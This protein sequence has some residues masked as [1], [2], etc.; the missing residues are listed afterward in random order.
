[1]LEHSWTT[2]RILRFAVLVILVVA[3]LRI[4]A[5]FIGALTWAGIIAITVWPAFLWL[6]GR[7]GGQPRLA[8]TLFTLALAAILVLPFTVLVVSLGDA[9]S[10]VAT[11]LKDLTAVTFPEPPDWLM[12][13]PL[14]GKVLDDAWRGA[15]TDVSGLFNAARPAIEKATIWT[16]AQGAQLGLALLEFLFAIIIAGVLLVTADRS[17]DWAQRVVAKVQIEGGP[18]LIAVVVSTVRSVSIGVGGTAVAQAV[19]AT[20]G[21]LIAGVPGVV[22][23]GFLTFL[24]ALVQIPTLLVWLPA[25]LWLYFQHQEGWA[26]FMLIWGL[27]AVGAVDNFLRPYL[28]SQGAKLPIAVIFIGVIGGLLAWGMIGL[29]IG[30]TL[31]AVAYSLLRNWVGDVR[32]AA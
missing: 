14:L 23:L 29:F 2:E 30:P 21:F 4:V 24:L 20:L 25:V 10:Q 32:A 6:A 8:A 12:Q 19:L 5:P 22:L 31:L 11:L 16:L 7:L 28:I 9:V 18:G 1:M 3:C 15:M 26:L 13:I 17:A 27:V